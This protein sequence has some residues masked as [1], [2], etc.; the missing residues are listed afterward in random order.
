MRR[1]LCSSW[2]VMPRKKLLTKGRGQGSITSAH[3]GW[4]H[5]LCNKI[6]VV[7]KCSKSQIM[8]NSL[9]NILLNLWSEPRSKF[10]LD[11]YHIDQQSTKHPNKKSVSK[12]F[13]F[14]FFLHQ[15]LLQEFLQSFDQVV[16]FQ[17]C[18]VVFLEILIFQGF[19]EKFQQKFL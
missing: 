8:R 10:F 7:L 12:K 2:D 4:N 6:C 13:Y 16:F 5:L 19:P 15:R 11:I 3:D 14:E 1:R 9:K 17:E 18:T